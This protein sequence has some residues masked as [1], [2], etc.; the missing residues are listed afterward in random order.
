MHVSNNA[1]LERIVFS[2]VESAEGLRI[3]N[4]ASLTE[5]PG[6]RHLREIRGRLVIEGN[7]AL[8]ALSLDALERVD[9]TI[10]IVDNPRLPA[11]AIDELL[12]RLRERGYAGSATIERNDD[13]SPC[14]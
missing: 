4:N 3:A 11:C 8:S 12:K 7:P 6:L 1:A 10:R 5:M 13:S 14:P 2:S 9:G